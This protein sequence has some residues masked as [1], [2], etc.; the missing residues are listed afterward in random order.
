MSAADLLLIHVEI[1]ARSNRHD[2]PT[3]TPGIFA[4]AASL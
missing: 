3:L 2:P 1:V 4:A